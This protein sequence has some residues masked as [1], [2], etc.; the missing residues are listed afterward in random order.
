MLSES[1][2]RASSPHAPKTPTRAT[3][4]RTSTAPEAARVVRKRAYRAQPRLPIPD[5]LPD[6]SPTSNPAQSPRR[7]NVVRKRAFR[8]PPRLPTQDSLPDPSPTP[9][10]T[11][12]P[13]DDDNGD[14][15]EMSHSASSL[16]VGPLA[17]ADCIALLQETVHAHFESLSLLQTGLAD[18]EKA[19]ANLREAAA[20]ELAALR[21]SL[22]TSSADVLRQLKESHE[23]LSALIAS[24]SSE[25]AR[26]TAV[27]SAHP[28]PSTVVPA[29]ITNSLSTLSARLDSTDTSIVR[30]SQDLAEAIL[31]WE[32]NMRS[33]RASSDKLL[34]GKVDAAALED[35]LANLAPVFPTPQSCPDADAV[36]RLTEALR[37][38]QLDFAASQLR[39][40]EDNK[41]ISEALARLADGFSPRDTLYSELVARL[42]TLESV[43]PVPP[44]AIPDELLKRITDLETSCRVLPGIMD[45]LTTLSQAPPAPVPSVVPPPASWLSEISSLKNWVS[46]RLPSR[47]SSAPRAESPPTFAAREASA[48][49]VAQHN[50]GYAP[51]PTPP[52]PTP[53]PSLSPAS[54]NAFFAVSSSSSA[55]PT[56]N[57][58]AFPPAPAFTTYASPA[59]SR[60]LAPAWPA[61]TSAAG[62][63]AHPA[64]SR[65]LAPEWPP[66]V[67]SASRPPPQ[68]PRM[69]N[70]RSAVTSSLGSISSRTIRT[71]SP[72]RI[73]TSS[74]NHF[75]ESSPNKPLDHVAA[76]SALPAA[77]P[78]AAY[79]PDKVNEAAVPLF[80]GSDSNADVAMWIMRIEMAVSKA[81]A[82]VDECSAVALTRSSGLLEAFLEDR[83]DSYRARYPSAAWEPWESLCPA[84][85][86]NFGTQQGGSAT[87]L[88][89][90]SEIQ[91]NRHGRH[92]PWPADVAEFW[93]RL[94]LAHKKVIKRLPPADHPSDKELRRI[95]V[96]GLPPLWKAKLMNWTAKMGNDYS[97]DQL[98]DKAM[99]IAQGAENLKL[100]SPP[101]RE[102]VNA[103]PVVPV[104]V[105]RPSPAASSASSADPNARR[106]SQAREK[107]VRSP[108]Q[109][110]TAAAVPPQHQPYKSRPSYSLAQEGTPTPEP[111]SAAPRTVELRCF[112]CGQPGHF[113]N[114]CTVPLR[115]CKTCQGNH[116]TQMHDICIQFF[117]RSP[118]TRSPTHGTAPAPTPATDSSQRQQRNHHHRGRPKDSA[119]AQ[120]VSFAPVEASSSN[121]NP[122]N[123]AAFFNDP[124]R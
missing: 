47:S 83:L 74:R 36:D 100:L 86:L 120:A 10:P 5:S 34:Q 123:Q 112:C 48:F 53:P 51:P 68:P 2:S 69:D 16:P 113:A 111:K 106:R 15:E 6:P 87:L 61:S 78:R 82:H 12:T 40:A 8:V 17:A 25:A 54:A 101:T 50:F 67:P 89:Q 110:A 107:K 63:L 103:A 71:P 55:R 14:W 73:P 65:P 66:A 26:T 58:A 27:T 35:R 44:P 41:N 91:C 64:P 79:K 115:H 98:K 60:S 19:T 38:L 117:P 77:A 108:T 28:P 21:D 93:T 23:N 7:T 105:P 59:Q 102:H 43:P 114:V 52:P 45:R 118:A 56:A 39:H 4:K 33:A 70:F 24:L 18:Q 3:T 94:T 85:K 109:E 11:P 9:D 119:Q 75:L 46:A 81:R 97:L 92:D 20:H 84:I 72:E 116:C 31:Q 90:L 96:A 37:T 121:A 32:S 30:L 88:S 49:Q 80:S 124:A 1:D 122:P 29:A 42:L 22:K 95:F 76:A 57:A 99:Q 104:P 13:M 62:S